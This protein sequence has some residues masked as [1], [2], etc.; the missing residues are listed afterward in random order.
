LFHYSGHAES[1]FAAPLESHLKVADGRLTVG[2][3]IADGALQPGSRVVL[4]A[5]ETGVAPVD[6]SGEYVGITAAFLMAGA[7]VVVSTLWMV[8]P[9]T[10]LIIACGLY[11]RDCSAPSAVRAASQRIRDSSWDDLESDAVVRDALKGRRL[12]DLAWPF[13]PKH[14]FH[15]APFIVCG[16]PWTRAEVEGA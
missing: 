15:W 2:S 1:N 11:S 9:A 10:P 8:D 13:P 14:P 5:C 6:P 12:R 16:A 3:L 4:L 7:S